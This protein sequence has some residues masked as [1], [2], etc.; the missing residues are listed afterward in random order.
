MITSVKNSILRQ[1][2]KSIDILNV[3]GNETSQDL[4]IYLNFLK[5]NGSRTVRL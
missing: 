4:D 3:K 5:V 1:K 2:Y